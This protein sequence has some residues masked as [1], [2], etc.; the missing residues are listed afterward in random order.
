M[1][2]TVLLLIILTIVSKFIG[3]GREII[4]S[5]FYG[6]SNV[7]DA[8]IIALTIPTVIFAFIGRGISTAFIPMYN[9]VDKNLGPEEANKFTNNLSNVLLVVSTVVVIFGMIFTEQIVR[10]FASGF[11]GSTLIL[12]TNFT[13]VSILGIYF[14]A[15][16]NVFKPYLQI[17]GNFAVPALIGFPMNFCIILSI[18]ISSRGNTMIL[19]YGIVASVLAQFIFMVPFIVKK[20]FRY[21]PIL[22]FK[23]THIKNMAY[24]ALPVILGVA[25]NDINKIIDRTL[26]SQIAEGGISAL[27]YAARLNGFVQGIIVMSIATAMYPLISKMAAEDNISGLKKT[28]SEAISGISI[29]VVPA[30]VGAMVLTQPIVELLFGR[31][32]FDIH[33][34]AMTS[35]A[36]FFYS[37]G[38]TGIGL[39]QVLSRPFYALQDTKTPVVNATI[40]VI[41]NIILN[42]ILSRYLGIGGLA[43]ATSISAIFT[44]IL[45]LISLRKKIGPFGMKQISISFV[46]ILFA[47]LV[48]GGVARLSYEYLK[49]NIFSQNLSLIISM[50]VGAIIYFVM[51]Y[52]MK[53]DEV[54]SM[55]NSLKAK[56]SKSKA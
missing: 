14:T 19:A 30:T 43:L 26:A 54:E 6:A 39:R 33:A 51:I 18:I 5:Y 38:M 9:K 7:S 21:T 37:I 4:L 42:I 22:N 16:I 45:M 35:N 25:V 48:M 27:N 23:E 10:V 49:A 56:I 15:L 32:A 3:F 20:G 24:L 13:R 55:I 28:L 17:K 29:L 1:K 12:A 41:L 52:I 40:G 44:A 47:S 34:V 46:K 50:G 2:K 11:E 31:G 8:Y 36:L 53:I